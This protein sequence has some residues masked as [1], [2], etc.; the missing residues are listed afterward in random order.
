MERRCDFGK[1]RIEL[2]VER[3]QT[4]ERANISQ[5]ADVGHLQIASTFAGSM[6]TPSAF[7]RCHKKETSLYSSMH[8]ETLSFNPARGSRSNNRSNLPM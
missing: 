4:E 2:P 8:L 1:L 7:T 6:D 3:A 5:T